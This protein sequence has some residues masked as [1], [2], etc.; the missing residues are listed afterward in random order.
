MVPE[1]ETME[2]M[3]CVGASYLGVSSPKLSD[4]VLMQRSRGILQCRKSCRA[5]PSRLVLGRLS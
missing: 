2:G 5:W 1:E 3:G 4:L